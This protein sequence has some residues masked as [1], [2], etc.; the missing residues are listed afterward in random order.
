MSREEA[1][2]YYEDDFSK[3]FHKE[4]ELHEYLQDIDERSWWRRTA[5]KNLK[6]LPVAGNEVKLTPVENENMASLAMDTMKH[7]GLMIRFGDEAYLLGNTVY[8]TLYGRA[9][10]HGSA[11]SE[12]ELKKLAYILNECLA[13]SPGKA[14]LHFSEGKIRA[15]PSGDEKDYSVIH[16][17]DIFL[18]AS[19]YIGN[20]FDQT[21]FS[22]GYTS[23]A[24]TNA[25]W[26]IQ[27]AKMLEAYRELLQHYGKK[28]VSDM[29]T[30]VRITTSDVTA[31]GVNIAYSIQADGRTIVL[32]QMLK[33]IHRGS[34]KLEEVEG[35]IQNIFSY[36]QEKLRGIEKLMKIPIQY[37]VNTLAGIMEKK[38]G[39][40]MIAETV[41]NFKNEIGNQPCTA[42]DVY[43][44]ICHVLFLAESKGAKTRALLELE[45]KISQC[46]TK[47]WKDYDMPGKMN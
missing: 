34:G 12:L 37:P 31:S 20:G 28:A 13:V 6:V 3:V 9:R 17:I 10:V 19:A 30:E 18:A 27:D 22:G 25:T 14:L 42:Y 4:K 24:L 47:P 43:C 39:K 38:F 33:T 36:Y 45:E 11:L 23:H 46:I 26:S 15:M 40:K 1:A 21:S 5:S 2:M 8:S 41:E 44:G 35:N 16:M 7:T 29:S 32:G